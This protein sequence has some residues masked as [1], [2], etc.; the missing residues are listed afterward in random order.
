MK[1]FLLFIYLLFVVSSVASC[2]LLR[3]SG[4]DISR[5]KTYLE[6]T[7]M[8][9]LDRNTAISM[10]KNLDFVIVRSNQLQFYEGRELKGRFQF[11]ETFTYMDDDGLPRTVPVFMPLKECQ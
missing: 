9:A 11:V 8:R 5:E 3:S 6:L 4:S 7:V 10:T 2:G 1:R